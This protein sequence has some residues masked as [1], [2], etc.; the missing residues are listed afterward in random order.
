MGENSIPGQ[1]QGGQV[2][3]PG[4]KY[5]AKV[6]EMAASETVLTLLRFSTKLSEARGY[7]LPPPGPEAPPGGITGTGTGPVLGREVGSWEGG[8]LPQ[9]YRPGC[10]M[11]ARREHA[12][13][14]PDFPAMQRQ[15]DRDT[16]HLPTTAR[17]DHPARCLSNPT[18]TQPQ[19]KGASLPLVVICFAERTHTLSAETSG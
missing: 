15:L 6:V 5:L 19:Q 2:Y 9:I 7:R 12:C 3:G 4:N 14:A 13:L 10:W 8:W 1:G 11:V 18:G 16:G 17:G